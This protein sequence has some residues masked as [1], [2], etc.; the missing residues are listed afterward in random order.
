MPS[1]VPVAVGNM[2]SPDSRLDITQFCE[3]L[4]PY[5][6]L[7]YPSRWGSCIF[8][9]YLHSQMDNDLFSM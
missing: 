2:S 1:Q 5:A 7:S 9:Q 4:P 3:I 8:F 6:V